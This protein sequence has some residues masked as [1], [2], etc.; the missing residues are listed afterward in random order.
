MVKSI[1]QSVKREWG[2]P[3]LSRLEEDVYIIKSEYLADFYPNKN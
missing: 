2:D 1:E 3:I